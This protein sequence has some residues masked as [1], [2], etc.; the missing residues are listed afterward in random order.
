MWKIN[1]VVIIGMAWGLFGA[2]LLTAVKADARKKKARE[3]DSD[4]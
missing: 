2:C 1:M 3:T 4:G